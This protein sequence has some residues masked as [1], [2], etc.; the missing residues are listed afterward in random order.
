MSSGL[1]D[2]IGAFISGMII[3]CIVSVPLTLWKLVEIVIWICHHV[4]IGVTP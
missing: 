1:G 2:A 3:L 4:H